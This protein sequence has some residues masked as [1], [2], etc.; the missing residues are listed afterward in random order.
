M[1]A[2]SAFKSR[3]TSVIQKKPE[4]SNV[5]CLLFCALV[6]RNP[7][8]KMHHLLAQQAIVFQANFYSLVTNV[9]MSNHNEQAQWNVPP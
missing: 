8:L 2:G 6:Q 4:G 3:A 1:H 7:L 5:S 9:F